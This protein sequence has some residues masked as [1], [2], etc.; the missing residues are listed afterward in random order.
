[1]NTP[2]QYVAGNVK[3]DPTTLAVAVRTNIWTH[4]GSHDWGVMTVDQGGRH[5]F[6]DEVQ[7]W[8]DKT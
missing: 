2:P 7:D 6:W 3:Q 4:D 8:K 1:M 5:A